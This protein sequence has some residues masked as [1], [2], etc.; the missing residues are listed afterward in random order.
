M[1][2]KVCGLNNPENISAIERVSGVDYT[3]FIFVEKSPRNAFGMLAPPSKFGDVCRV[4]VFMNPSIEQIELKLKLF[5][6]DIIQLHGS[7][8]PTFCAEVRKLTRVFKA[9]GIEN[10]N[11]LEV[12]RDYENVCDGFVL[13]K[14]TPKGGGS[15]EKYDW[16][17]LANY[18]L[19]TPYLL[20]GGI[21]LSDAQSLSQI[22]L[23]NCMG[24]DV[25]SR[26]ES[27]PGIKKVEE[28]ELFIKQSKK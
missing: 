20:S 15:G 28:I 9:F 27:T 17:I 21:G 13:D 11:D 4:G 19:K 6:L 23:P 18:A 16:A 12:L 1:K 26:F 10:E 25:N 22:N 7:E 24:Y 8:T 3:G 2:L 5:D 14:K